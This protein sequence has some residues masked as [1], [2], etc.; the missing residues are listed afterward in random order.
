MVAA[1][2]AIW[3]LLASIVTAILY[4]WDKR[5]AIK[6]HPRVSEN[7]LLTWSCLGGWP[8]ALIAGRLIRHKT[9]KTSY[10]VG[11]VICAVGNIL[12]TLTIL[13]LTRAW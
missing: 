9:I 5:S 8:G 6:D 2:L 10:R 4:V 1:G 12:A 3:I 13:Y 7:T 11:F